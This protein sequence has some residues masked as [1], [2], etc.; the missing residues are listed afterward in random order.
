MK[1]KFKNHP[2]GQELKWLLPFYGGCFALLAVISAVL[3]IAGA[4]DYTLI[5]GAAAGTA[6]SAASFIIMGLSAEK[7]VTMGGKSARSL[8]NFSYGARYIATFIIL[9]ALMYLKLVNPVTAIVPLFVPKI[10]YTVRAAFEK[11]E[12]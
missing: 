4:G 11:T 5:T 1:T 9:G 10:G 12:F 7:A 6:V 8:M 3:I 2:S